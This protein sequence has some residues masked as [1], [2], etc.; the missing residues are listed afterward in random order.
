MIMQ[1]L[2]IMSK[3]VLKEMNKD[4]AETKDEINAVVASRRNKHHEDQLSNAIEI[5]KEKAIVE[6]IQNPT[7]EIKKSVIE[8]IPVEQKVTI[9]L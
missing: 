7:E 3:K 5:I 4:Y 6:L 8:Q 2:I 1:N 9:I